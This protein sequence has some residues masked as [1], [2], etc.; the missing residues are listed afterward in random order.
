MKIKFYTSKKLQEADEIQ[1]GDGESN[2]SQETNTN[3]LN[4]TQDK[5]TDTTEL[6][7]QLVG[8]VN[9]KT[10]LKTQ[11]DADIKV[12]NDQITLLQKQRGDLQAADAQTDEQAQAN[13]AKLI[14]TNIAL[15]DLAN[16]KLVKKTAY[17]QNIKNI[18]QQMVLINKTI[19]ENGGDVDVKCVDESYRSKIRFSKK[20]Y[21]AV[22][23]RT[24]EM[25]A[26]I[27]MA[28]DNIDNLS[29]RPE[30][31]KCRTFAKNII[32]YL[33]KLGWESGEHENEFKT[34]LFNLINAS[35][36][37]LAQSEKE[38]FI[39]NLI[40]LMKEN[41][42]FMWIFYNK[43]T[44]EFFYDDRLNININNF[45]DDYFCDIK[46]DD[47]EKSRYIFSKYYLIP[48]YEKD[49]SDPKTIDD[50]RKALNAKVK[51]YTKRKKKF[52]TEEFNR[53]CFK[54]VPVYSWY[55]M[56][57]YDKTKRRSN[58]I[59][60]DDNGIFYCYYPS[61]TNN[62]IISSIKYD[63]N[64]SLIENLEDLFCVTPYMKDYE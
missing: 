29:Y 13:K 64:K 17:Q 59:L 54:M 45:N 56:I 8:F 55:K 47:N 31:T 52:G 2:A 3:I 46:L 53:S 60:I 9:R 18:E 62:G 26:E 11:Y 43:L 1:N 50:V 19:A 63:F 24:D 36:I 23:N 16:K 21:E 38:K 30:N 49:H 37:S 5:N 22:L 6:S 34:F 39:N 10:Q 25:Y 48:K 57:F 32:A 28:F 42:L 15:N 40:D 41:T 33:N 20:L 51:V 58:K 14:Q 7:Q 44:E 61:K 4:Q 12:L 35:H 27:C